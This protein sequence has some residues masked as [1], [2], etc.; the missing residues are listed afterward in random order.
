[1]RPFDLELVEGVEA[2]VLLD[3]VLRNPTRWQVLVC[4]EVTSWMVERSGFWQLLSG[5]FFLA[6]SS[7]TCCC[8]LTA[9][10]MIQPRRLGRMQRRI[11]FTRKKTVET[12]DA[13]A[14]W[15]LGAACLRLHLRD[16]FLGIELKLFRGRSRGSVALREFA[17]VAWSASP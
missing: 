9:A 11:D 4:Q 1:M 12:R 13:K 2:F 14:E 5:Q 15:T 16:L 10:G 3:G 17:L 8:S 6:W 7:R